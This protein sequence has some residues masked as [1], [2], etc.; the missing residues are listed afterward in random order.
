MRSM[1]V[2]HAYERV[3]VPQGVTVKVEGKRVRVSGPLGSVEKDF[4][5]AKRIS[6]RLEDGAVVVEAF[7]AGKREY[8]LVG[9]LAAH[10]R[11]M[12]K[13]VTQGYRYRL[14]MVYA[15]FPMSVK[16]EGGRV[17]IENFLGERGRR[18]AAILPGVRVRVDKDEVI[19]EG[20]DKDAVAQ[21][22]ANI[23]PVSY[24]HLTLPTSD[25]V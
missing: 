25:L 20:I 18:Y 7:N 22:A 15:H 4:S 12:I 3:E 23:H 6:L 10:I 1:R 17:V 8:A 13:G 11:N 2:L 14:K 5:H 16:V 24:T 21:T 9:T 19:V